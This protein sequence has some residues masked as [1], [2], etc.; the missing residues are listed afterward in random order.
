MTLLLLL[1]FLPVTA[2]GPRVAT[3]RHDGTFPQF[4]PAG[5]FLSV[6]KM[7]ILVEVIKTKKKDD[8]GDDDFF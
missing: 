3:L 1:L 6:R 7:M 5:G 8:N 4:S 2:R